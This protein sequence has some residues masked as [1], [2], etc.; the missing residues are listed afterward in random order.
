MENLGKNIMEFRRKNNL[1]QS[2]LGQKLSISAQAVSKWEKGLSEPD[3]DTLK[4]MCEI[5]SCTINELTDSGVPSG[6]PK[7][8]AGNGNSADPL[9]AAGPASA[10]EPVIIMG[11]C[12]ECNKPLNNVKDYKVIPGAGGAPQR[13]LCNKCYTKQLYEAA[14]GN[15][16]EHNKE[17]RRS[18]IWASVAA[19]VVLVVF[20]TAGISAGNYGLAF[21][22]GIAAAYAAFALVAQIFW[23]NAVAECM[24]FFCRSFRMPGL[25]FSL[26]LDGIIW[27][28]CVK[29]T[30]SVLASL[31]SVLCFAAG[32]VIS[33]CFAAIYFPFGLVIFIREGNEEKQKMTDYHRQLNDIN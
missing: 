16:E 27:F 18:M 20:L 8:V 25:I 29:L 23:L 31:L 5:F 10:A 2:E 3:I 13:V 17:L 33:A 12:T 28:I 30:L 22:G 9:P 19:A 14:N 21:G 6:E 1:T 32:L 24:G 4:K 11:Y 15:V 26:D 7:S